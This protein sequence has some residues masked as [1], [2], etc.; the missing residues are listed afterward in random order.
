MVNK[1]I[2]KLIG[3]DGNAFA[4]IGKAQG[5]MKKHLRAQGKSNA[6]IKEACDKI[7]KEMTSGDYDNL[8]RVVDNYF[9]IN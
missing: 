9:E 4:I 1:P 8:L 2:L 6:E 7:V 3:Q 5:A